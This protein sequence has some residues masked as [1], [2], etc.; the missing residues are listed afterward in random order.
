MQQQRLNTNKNNRKNKIT[1]IKEKNKLSSLE[2]TKEKTLSLINK[3]NLV[4]WGARG[5]GGGG[6]GG[7]GGGGGGGGGL[8]VVLR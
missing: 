2:L 3:L 8:V 6:G 4:I 7:W 1:T 5:G